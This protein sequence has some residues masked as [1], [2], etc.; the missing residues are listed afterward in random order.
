MHMMAGTPV[1]A[2]IQRA[3]RLIWQSRIKWHMIEVFSL[4]ALLKDRQG[5]PTAA[6]TLLEMAVELAQSGGFIRT[7]VDL[8]KPIAKL[9]AAL[10]GREHRPFVQQLLTSFDLPIVKTTSYDEAQVEHL[11]PL[12]DPLTEREMDVLKLLAQDL[13]NREI[14]LQLVIS[15]HTVNFHLKNI[16]TKLHVHGRRQADDVKVAQRLVAT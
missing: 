5:E 10:P 11:Q 8:G 4:Q 14:A 16:Y 1:C 2:I 13:T 12:V 15:P 3:F 6:L 7:F 9:L